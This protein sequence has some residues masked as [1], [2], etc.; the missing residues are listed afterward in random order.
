METF[1]QVRQVAGKI[2]GKHCIHGIAVAPP[3]DDVGH[4]FGLKRMPCRRAVERQQKCV[5]RMCTV[6]L[7]HRDGLFE[8][9]QTRHVKPHERGASVGEH[10]VWPSCRYGD[11]RIRPALMA[12]RRQADS[13]SGTTTACSQ[14]QDKR[15]ASVP[16]FDDGALVDVEDPAGFKAD[17]TGRFGPFVDV[18]CVKV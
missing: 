10:R 9:S 13:C 4:A 17:P 16:V 2:V 3:F 8:F 6:R 7:H 11:A 14:P 15:A 12:A 5:S 1:S 18:E